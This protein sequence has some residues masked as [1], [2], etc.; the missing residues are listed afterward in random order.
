MSLI[1]SP[2]HVFAAD[3]LEAIAPTVRAS[4]P[5]TSI[6]MGGVCLTVGSNPTKEADLLLERAAE[7][8]KNTPMVESIW[9]DRIVE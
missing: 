2:S 7:I 5:G 8:R 6:I 9:H 4:A 1:P 3:A